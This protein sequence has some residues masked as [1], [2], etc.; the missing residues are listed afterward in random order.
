MYILL[1]LLLDTVKYRRH[2]S[3]LVAVPKVSQSFSPLKLSLSLSFSY[4]TSKSEPELGIAP[5]PAC[6]PCQETNETNNINNF[7]K[8]LNY[9]SKCKWNI[10]TDNNS[11]RKTLLADKNCQ[12]RILSQS[13]L[14]SWP[15][16]NQKEMII[17]RRLVI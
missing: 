7:L 10:L 3:Y 1:Y 2:C 6:G 13:N 14:C 16:S 12:E 9:S 17:C 8:C 4:P 15:Y 11:E 5:V